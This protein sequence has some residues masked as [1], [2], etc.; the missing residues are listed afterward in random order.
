MK[1][2]KVVTGT[3]ALAAV[4]AAPGMSVAFSGGEHGPRHHKHQMFERMAEK[5]ELT[6]GQKAQLKANREAGRESRMAE[7]KEMRELRDQLR[8]AVDSEADQA[9]LDQLSVELGRLKVAEMQRRKKMQ[10]QFE[11]ILTDE[12]K[13]KLEQ[14]KS[15][16]KERWQERRAERQEQTQ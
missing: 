16:R 14:M 5:L 13:A 1:N 10:E 3:M 6:E 11:A 7:R 4:L 2:W 12:Q 8:E 15:E 9:T